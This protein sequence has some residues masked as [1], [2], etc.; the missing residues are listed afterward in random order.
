MFHTFASQSVVSAEEWNKAKAK[1]KQAKITYINTSSKSS[2]VFYPAECILYVHLHISRPRIA[3]F[4]HKT[5]EC[6]KH[7]FR[8]LLFLFLCVIF[9]SFFF[10]FFCFSLLRPDLKFTKNREK[11]ENEEYRARTAV[12]ENKNREWQWQKN[13]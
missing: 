7:F 3:N 11:Q 2:N 8:S 6:W 10:F 1:T 13:V 12:Q 9:R 5:K 4:I